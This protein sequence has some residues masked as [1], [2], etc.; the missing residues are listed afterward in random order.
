MFENKLELIIFKM[1]RIVLVF[2]HLIVQHPHSK[3][4][5]R[6]LVEYGI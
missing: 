2:H 6:L 5:G 4:Y 3:F 1:V